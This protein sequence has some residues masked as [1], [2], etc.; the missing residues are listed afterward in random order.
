[1]FAKINLF[2]LFLTIAVLFC[3]CAPE[4]NFK[5]SVDGYSEAP[6]SAMLNISN[7]TDESETAPAVTTAAEPTTVVLETA[8]T[9]EP[10]TTPA[11]ATT[12]EPTREVTASESEA[13]A[14]TTAATES[15]AVSAITEASNAETEKATAASSYPKKQE[16]EIKDANGQNLTWRDYDSY[17]Y[18][19]DDISFTV[20]QDTLTETGIEYTLVNNFEELSSSLDWQLQKKIDGQW[21]DLN[22]ISGED[23]AIMLPVGT[24][25]KIYNFGK[26]FG[27]LEPGEYRVI[28]SAITEPDENSE[29][30][31]GFIFLS[32]EFTVS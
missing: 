28:F 3:S 21:Y 25:T 1:M 31:Y 8:A 32:S 12:P 27:S 24:R 19:G 6:E 9:P 4:N 2:A 23:E 18:T 13:P 16:V 30:R 29:I 7:S 20:L 17:F 5:E 10:A 22:Y 11:A 26:Y 15:E 14:Q